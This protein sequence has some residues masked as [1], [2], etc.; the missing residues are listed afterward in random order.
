[1]EDERK[2]NFMDPL[3][4]KRYPNKTPPRKSYN[5]HAIGKFVLDHLY[6]NLGNDYLNSTGV[7]WGSAEEHKI[8]HRELLLR[9]KQ[10]GLRR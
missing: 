3:V 5:W 8:F 6:T 10:A 9:L 4:L 2:D 1:M 7:D